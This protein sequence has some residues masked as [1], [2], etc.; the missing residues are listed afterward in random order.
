MTKNWCKERDKFLVPGFL[1]QDYNQLMKTIENS[2]SFEKS[3]VA[4]FRLKCLNHYYN[5]GWKSTCDAYEIS[6]S[7]LYI[8]KHKYEKSG[9]N[10][11]KLVPKKTKPK[12]VRNMKTDYRFIE[13]IKSM[14]QEYGNLSKYK[15]KIFVDE[16]ALKLNIATISVSTIGKIIKRKNFFFDNQSRLVPIDQARKQRYL[17]RQRAKKAPRVN[18]SGF[19]ELD[20]I[21]TF[22]NGQKFQ[23]ICCLDVYTKVAYS[24]LVPTLSSEQALKTL[25]EFLK[26]YPVVVKTIQ[27]DNG[28]EFLG[29]FNDYLQQKKIKHLFTY[30]RCPRINGSIE[31]YNRTFQEECV[32]RSDAIY[33]SKSEFLIEMESYFLW[34]NFHRPHQA[35]NYLSP[36]QFLKAS[37][38]KS[39]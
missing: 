8:W 5:Y 39:V 15:L 11:N 28:S 16:L 25:L 33:Y 38:P 24:K 3:D 30:P 18:H 31:R 17:N 37:F 22:I 21:T 9:G 10:L 27:T 4:A 12:R 7:I 1:K 6:K 36:M 23:F 20:S 35:L 26:K 14:R 34:Y 19:L 2:L 13:L 32:N 29:E